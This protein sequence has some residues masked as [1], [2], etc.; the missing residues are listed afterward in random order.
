MLI[1]CSESTAVMLA[2]LIALDVHPGPLLFTKRPDIVWELIAAL[3][4]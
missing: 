1:P 2:A 4:I 3:Y